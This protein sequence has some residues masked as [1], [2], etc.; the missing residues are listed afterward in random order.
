MTMKMLSKAGA[1]GAERL[2]GR[3]L[4]VAGRLSAVDLQVGRG[5]GLGVV[6][7]SGAGK[8][9]LARAL[10]GLEPELRGSLRFAGQELV[11]ARRG[12]WAPLR[13]RVQLVWQD[14]TT[15]LDP[16]LTI[17]RSIAEARALAGRDRFS[18][19]DARLRAL[20]ARVALDPALL[21]RVP[22]ALSGGQRQRA[23]IARALAAE[24]TLMIVDEITSALDRPVAWT[25]VDLLRR[26]RGEQIGLVMISHDLSLLPGTVDRVLVLA[27]GR[28]VEQGPISE[29]LGRP[30]EAV[31]RELVAAAQ[32]SH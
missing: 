12:G 32:R 31:T 26:L 24:P 4:S 6:G 20:L 19:D 10:V 18:R 28:T 27:D 15:A 5:D 17:G 16:N 21:Q 29:V 7:R 14:P 8:S 22:G 1:E 30:R 13:A 2:V 11:G 25:I 3:G 9:T 23:A